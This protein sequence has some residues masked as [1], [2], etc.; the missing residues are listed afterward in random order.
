MSLILLTNYVMMELILTR[1]EEHRIIRAAQNLR[2]LVLDELHTYR[3]R[4][5]ADVGMLVRR[6]REDLHA[7]SVQHIGTSATIAGA[8][9][10]AA[11]Q[12][13]VAEMAS[14][15]FGSTVKPEHV[16]GE[17]LRRYTIDSNFSSDSF[18]SSLKQAVLSGLTAEEQSSPDHFRRNPLAAW[19]E[20]TFGLTK[21]NGSERKRRATPLPVRGQGGAAE[22]LAWDTRLNPADD[23]LT[24]DVCASAIEAIL[25]AGYINQR[26][27]KGIIR[28][29]LNPAEYEPTIHQS[30]LT[31]MLDFP[32]LQHPDIDALV[33]AFGTLCRACQFLAQQLASPAPAAVYPPAA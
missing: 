19:I 15:L 24:E 11:Q 22:K 26:D 3:G 6:I 17:Y 28:D 2:F 31:A 27:G 14:A 25:M 4:Q 21:E 5:G 8:E 30:A 23:L 16:I 32:H 12:T 33:P 18:K 13:E 1:N 29:H 7:Y 10:F 9:T 20:A